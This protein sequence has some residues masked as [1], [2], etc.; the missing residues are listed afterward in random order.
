MLQ[1]REWEHSSFQMFQRGVYTFLL[2]DEHFDMS[3]VDASSID[4]DLIVSSDADWIQP[5]QQVAHILIASFK[6][7][8]QVQS[9]CAQF[10][11]GGI[12][13]WTLLSSYD[14]AAREQVYERELRLCELLRIYDFDFRVTSIDLVSP[15]ELVEAGSREIFKR[16]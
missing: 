5:E 2:G 4:L 12:T 16:S 9:I 15:T 8:P 10:D 7:V 3:P 14:R 11:A 13:I 6:E 1:E